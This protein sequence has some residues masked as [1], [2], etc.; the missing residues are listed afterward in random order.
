MTTY[1]THI[2]SFRAIDTPEHTL[3]NIHVHIYKNVQVACHLNKSYM[4]GQNLA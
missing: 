1:N 2:D 4:V 3:Y